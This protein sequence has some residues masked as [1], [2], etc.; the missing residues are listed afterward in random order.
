MVGY[1]EESPGVKSITRVAF[2][3]MIANAL[4]VVDYQL[5]TT[6]H[7]DIAAFLSMVSAACG[8]KLWSKSIE[9]KAS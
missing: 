5:I 8:L 2:F 1:F 4:F 3:A 6:A 7:I 9:T